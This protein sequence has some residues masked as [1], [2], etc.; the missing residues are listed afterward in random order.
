MMKRREFITSAGAGLVVTGKEV[1]IKMKWENLGIAPPYRDHRIAF[2]L[3]KND[4]IS[5]VTITS[6]SI[7]GWLPGETNISLN[8]KL[9][10]DLEK[11][12]YTLELGIVFHSSI[13][14]TIPID[15]KG[16]TDDEWYRIGSMKVSP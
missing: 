4:V 7:K 6:Q 8:Y 1:P 3:K 13:K 5:G 2:R 15:N 14:H 9:P 11:G 12:N 16:K 10:A